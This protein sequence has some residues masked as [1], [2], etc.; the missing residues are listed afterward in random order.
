MNV[1]EYIKETDRR[2]DDEEYAASV[3]IAGPIDYFGG[4]PEERHER[5]AAL[6]QPNTLIICP[7][8][9]QAYF[10]SAPQ[11]MF[12]RNLAGSAGAS[13]LIAVWAG[14]LIQPSFGTP[15]ELVTAAADKADRTVVVGSMGDSMTAQA[16]RAR[17]VREVETLE[18]AVAL[19]RI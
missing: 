2:I 3:Y 4:E 5:L 9:S 7:V 19:L 6:V 12:S 13:H 15:I 8:C 14:P 16:L 11:V 1:E 17:G 18:E 10:K